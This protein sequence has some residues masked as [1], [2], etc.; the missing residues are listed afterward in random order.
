MGG[1]NDPSNIIRVSIEE[2]SLAHKKL[3]EEYGKEEDKIAYL[4]LS[5]QASSSDIKKLKQRLGSIKG[6]ERVKELNKITNGETCRKGGNVAFQK[7][8]GIHSPTW[9]KSIGGKKGGL[10]TGPTT[11][12]RRWFTNG[13]EDTRVHINNLEDFKISN[14]T[15]YFGRTFK[16]S[17]GKESNT[18]N[19]TWINKNGCNKRIKNEDLQRYLDDGFSFGMVTKT[20]HP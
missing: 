4:A 9:D 5:G 7:K 1:S 10:K 18:K 11:K 16:P 17:L 12:D 19:T 6:I 8:L 20:H 13:S 2:H 15:W 3:W 14:P